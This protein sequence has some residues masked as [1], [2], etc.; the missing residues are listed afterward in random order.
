[1]QLIEAGYRG[2]TDYQKTDV[3]KLKLTLHSRSNVQTRR[4]A[5]SIP[6]RL[7]EP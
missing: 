4:E 5:Q 1:M 6:F 3:Q 2:M 7:C